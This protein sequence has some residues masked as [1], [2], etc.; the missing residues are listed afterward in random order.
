MESGSERND[1]GVPAPV[2]SFKHAGFD[3]VLL[4]EVVR[5]GFEAPTPIQAQALP[6]IMSVSVFGLVFVYCFLGGGSYYPVAA[7]EGE[8]QWV[9]VRD[10]MNIPNRPLLCVFVCVFLG[11]GG[12]ES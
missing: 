11:L 10:Y 9:Y 1:A 4:S 7:Y 12:G 8:G 5:Q 3:D 6:V 2:R